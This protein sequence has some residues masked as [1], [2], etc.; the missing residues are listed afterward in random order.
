MSIYKTAVSGTTIGLVVVLILVVAGAG[1]YIALNP[2]GGVTT[3]TNTVITSSGMGPSVT[4]QGAGSSL[5]AP[6][7]SEWAFAYQAVSNTHVNYASVGSGQGIASITAGTVNFGASDAPL[8]ASQYAALPAGSTLLTIPEAASGVIPAYNIPASDGL[9]APVRFTGDVL[10]KIFLGNITMWNDP[11]LQALNPGV[12]LPAQPISVVHRSDGS[13]T[14]FAFTNFLSDSNA[15]WRQHVGTG[16]LPKWPVGKGCLHNEGVANC[17]SGTPYSLGPLEIAYEIQ[18]PKLISYG[19]V[20][21][22]AGNFVLANL[23][24]IAS[25][26]GAGATGLPA[27]DASWTTVSIINNIFNDTKDANIYPITTFTY[28]MVYEQQ[29]GDQSLATATVNFMWWVVNSAQSAGSSL[30]Y[31]PLPASVVAIDDASINSITYNGAAIHT[32][33]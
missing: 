6:L 13:G 22:A 18:N 1:A 10:A 26:L 24:N 30:G 11:A 19:S 7:M 2:G 23:T 8:T 31:P 15:F 4:I 17:I 5:V 32:G 9:T 25:A 12:S 16:T 3:V 14:M 21:N 27:G 28:F 33:S 29:T 20:Q